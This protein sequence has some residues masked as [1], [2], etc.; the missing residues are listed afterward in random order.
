MATTDI[1]GMVFYTVTDPVEP[2]QTLLNGISTATTNALNAQDRVFK[3]ANQAAR[4]TL[5]TQR[6]APLTVSRT[7][8]GIWERN[9]GSGWV[10]VLGAP[11]IGTFTFASGWS[12]YATDGTFAP[13]NVVKTNGV[14]VVTG[15]VRKD[16]AATSP[17][18][19]V[20]TLP[21]GF[22]PVGGVLIQSSPNSVVA[23]NNLRLNIA[24]N[25]TVSLG[26]WNGASITWPNGE[27]A[28]ISAAFQ[29]M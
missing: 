14:V 27:F 6:G 18:Q 12:N 21:A 28:T 29:G 5:Y 11:Q 4:D 15:L 20:G 1:N 10:P 23:T 17:S 22:R 25:G 7:D 19:T 16:G 8:T 13:M 3:V 26:S 24:P 9:T 2:L